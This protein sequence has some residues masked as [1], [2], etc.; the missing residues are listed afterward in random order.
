MS[1]F[2]LKALESCFKQPN[3]Q[4]SFESLYHCLGFITAM[5]SSPDYIQPSEW[6]EQLVITEDKTPRFD[7]EEQVKTF[8]ANLIT[9]W[10]QCSQ[11]FDLGG[12]LELPKKLGLTPGGKPNKALVEFSTG[13]L[14]GFDWLFDAWQAL[15]PEE[16]IEANRTV[17]VLNFI[18]ARFVDEK[19][20]SKANPELYQELPDTKGCFKV[21]P[22]LI[23]G[24]GMLGQDL[25]VNDEEYDEPLLDESL[26]AT[27][28]PLELDDLS[29]GPFQNIHRSVGRNDTCPCGSGK[30]FKKCCL[31]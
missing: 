28:I 15:L 10:D 13:Y 26:E 21:L 22:N 18:L 16:N 14:D 1:T 20:M 23:S 4:Q 7:S 30:K 11:L 31:H 6:M 3:I 5:A 12:T 17:S 25:A 19:M 29:D 24:V 8:T 2:D 9:W 27:E